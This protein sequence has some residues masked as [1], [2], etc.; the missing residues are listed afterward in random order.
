[1]MADSAVIIGKS[2]PSDRVYGMGASPIPATLSAAMCRS[3]RRAATLYVCHFHF[4]SHSS[5]QN[6]HSPAYALPQANKHA[7]TRF[8]LLS[9]TRS[10]N[11]NKTIPASGPSTAISPGMSR[12]VFTPTSWSGRPIL[13]MWLFRRRHIR[14]AEIGRV[15]R[16][17]IC[18]R[19]LIRGCE[20]GQWRGAGVYGVLEEEKG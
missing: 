7:L 2:Y 20:G 1:M 18:Y 10:S 3:C 19:R 15:I 8:H 13:R 6:V 9:L 11:G 16:V 14:T 5:T 17:G 12:G 4:R